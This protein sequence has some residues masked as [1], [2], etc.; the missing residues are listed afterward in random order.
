M[1]GGGNEQ[2]RHD[3]NPRYPE[4]KVGSEVSQMTG[5][6]LQCEQNRNTGSDEPM[7]AVYIL[8]SRLASYVIADKMRR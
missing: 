6:F 8:M 5:R 3:S 2:S 4:Q 7:K 1:S